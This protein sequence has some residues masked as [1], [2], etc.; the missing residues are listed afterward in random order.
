M[1]VLVDGEEEIAA[2]IKGEPRDVPSMCEGECVGGITS[3]IVSALTAFT[4]VEDKY[5]TRSNTVTLFPTGESR[6][7]PSGVKRR[8]PLQ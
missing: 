8:L 1:A 3:R 5:C 6:Q 7:V 2:G 4:R